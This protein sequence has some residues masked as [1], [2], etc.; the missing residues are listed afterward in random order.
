M[1]SNEFI[2]D[3]SENY[4]TKTEALNLLQMKRGSFFEWTKNEGVD[5]I[6]IGKVSLYQKDDIMDKR[7]AA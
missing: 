3:L 1:Y 4:F 6:L 7:R 5:F 2:T